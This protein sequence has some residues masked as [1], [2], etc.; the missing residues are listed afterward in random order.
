MPSTKDQVLNIKKP[1]G[2]KK[3]WWLKNREDYWNLWLINSAL[4]WGVTIRYYLLCARFNLGR[5]VS[6]TPTE[7]ENLDLPTSPREFFRE[8]FVAGSIKEEKEANVPS[9]FWVFETKAFYREEPTSLELAVFGISEKRN[10]L[11]GI[12]L[13]SWRADAKQV[14]DQNSSFFRDPFMP[15]PLDFVEVQPFGYL[16]SSFEDV[17]RESQYYAYYPG[18][19]F[20][21]ITEALPVAGT[22]VGPSLGCVLTAVFDLEH[23]KL[24]TLNRVPD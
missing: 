1:R 6:P 4:L 18:S 17:T 3:D 19:R 22:L 2:P 23:R 8:E 12:P 15:L 24:L 13:D 7:K 5:L 10:L 9:K 11:I 14:I 20:Y 16:D 21:R